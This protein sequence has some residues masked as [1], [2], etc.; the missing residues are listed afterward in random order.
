MPGGKYDSSKTRVKP[1]FDKL[2]TRGRDWLPQLLAL[3][4]GGCADAKVRSVDLTLIDG[5][6]EPREKCLNPPISLLSW[7]IR[8]VNLLASK[9]LDDEFRRRLAIGDP[10]TIEHALHLLRT[11]GASRAWYV[12][13]GPTCPDAYLVA[14]DALVVIEGKR[15]ER[16]TTIDTTWLN[17]RHQIWR[18]LDAAW[19]IRGRRAVYGLL[20]VESDAASTDGSVPEVWRKAGQACLDP[21]SLVTSFPHRSA[22]EVVAISRCYL[23]VTT[24][25]KVCEQ[26]DIDWRKLPHEVSSLGG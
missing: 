14:Q 12:F 10:E 13:E 21:T 18:H 25:R 1:V 7:L 15:S 11:E 17:G 2:W 8:N 20:I 19:E 22:E 3:P 9:P 5:F 24:W 26:F 6:W 4:T 16:S 23:G